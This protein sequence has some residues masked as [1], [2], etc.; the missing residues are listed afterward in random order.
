MRLI[1]ILFLLTAP[2]ASPVFG[3]PPDRQCN[4]GRWGAIWCIRNDFIAYDTCLAIRNAAALH[5]LDTGFFARLIWQESRFDPYALSPAGAEGVAQFMPGTAKLRGLG[6]S[7]NPAEALDHSAHYLAELIGRFGNAGL[8]AVAYNGGERRAAEFI[9]ETGGLAQETE[10]YVRIITGQSAQ[11]W[12]DTPPEIL[13]MSLNKDKPFLPACLAL[14]RTSRVSKLKSLRPVPTLP[15]WGV[16]LA[17]GSTKAK[18]AS[19]FE[20]NSHACDAEI[21][22]QK[23][24]YIRKKPQVAGRKAYYVARLGAVS[25]GA[26]QQLCNRL[27]KFNCACTVYKN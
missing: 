17:S 3:E 15:P 16:Q 1:F 10:N 6:A 13:D 26:A 7:Y 27:R 21:G 20:R 25:R 14:A 22:K 9:A 19:S 8:A 23:P 5:K 4:T 2:L 11:D 24:A 12:R 18:A